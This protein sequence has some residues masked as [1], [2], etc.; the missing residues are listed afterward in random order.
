MLSWTF[1]PGIERVLRFLWRRH[2]GSYPFKLGPGWKAFSVRCNINFY[3]NLRSEL[4]TIPSPG[5]HF[6]S[7]TQ[8]RWNFIVELQVFNPS[9]IQA[10]KDDDVFHFVSFLPI[11]GRIYELDGLKVHFWGL[12]SEAIDPFLFLLTTSLITCNTG[13]AYWSWS[14]RPRLDQRSKVMPMPAKT[15]RKFIWFPRIF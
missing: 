3:P 1:V 5:R 12:E 6:L 15:I 8:R 7:S 14:C 10:E 9:N 4:C 11:G 13:R 2:E